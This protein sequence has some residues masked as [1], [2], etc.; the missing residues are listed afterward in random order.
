MS[1]EQKNHTLLCIV[2]PEGCEIEA[3]ESEGEFVFAKGICPRG[4]DYAKQEIRNPARI[5]TSTIPVLRG[6]VAMLPVRS[7]LPIPKPK[8]M[9]AMEEVKRLHVT[10]P[11][12]LGQI[13]SSNLS[14]TGINLVAGRSIRV[15]AS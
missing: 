1:N 8:I 5:L 2:C 13:V 14:G 11:V 10:A 9:A 3:T 12:E 6:E 15:S 7:A 4:Q